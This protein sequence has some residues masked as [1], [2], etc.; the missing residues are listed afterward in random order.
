VEVRVEVRGV[1]VAWGEPALLH[2]VLV[3]LLLNA[4]DAGARHIVL[5]AEPG[6]RIEVE[7]DG[8]GVPAENLPR[9]FEPFFTTRP[10]G[11]G[12]GLGLAIAHRILEQHQGRIE[13]R[14]VPGTGTTFVLSL[15]EPARG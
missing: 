12:T 3:N 6:V 1:P 2:Q 5:R 9:L 10:P 4:A 8:E 11:K 14:S 13:V 7:D 15:P